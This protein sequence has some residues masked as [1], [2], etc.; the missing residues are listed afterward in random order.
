MTT[1]QPERVG[2]SFRDPL[3]QVF[4]AGDEVL[5]GLRA[6]GVA[7]F[8][9]VE[10]APF[11]TEALESR[12]IVATE[13]VDPVAAGLE[14]WPVVLRHEKVPVVSY[15]Y[16]WTFSMLRDA[17]LLQLGLTRAALADS[18]ITKDATPF[19]VQFEGARP[20]FIDVGSFEPY[21][22]GEPW[23]GYEQFCR[24]FL[25]PL[26]L[27][28]RCG[29]PFQPVLRG[30]L[31]GISPGEIRS[32][33][34]FRDRWRRGMFSHVTL[35]ARAQAKYA[36]GGD[37]LRG[38]LKTAGFGAPLIDAQLK[39]L[40]RVVRSI[41]WGSSS[42]TWSDYSD[43]SHYESEELRTKEDFVRQTCQ[44]T[45]PQR[46]V[47][48]GA[49]DGHFSKI[50]AET[51][52]TVIAVDGDHLVVD[53]LYQRLREDGDESILPLVM[54]LSD[55]SPATGW[56]GKERDAF[57]PRADADLVL[58]LALVHHL[59]ISATVPIPDIVAWLADFEADVV[60][61]FPH[62]D[63]PMV[64][65]LLSTKR[66]GLFDGYDLASFEHALADRFTITARVDLPTRT[67]FSLRRA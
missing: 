54:D 7:D 13:R 9:A 52:R 56:R 24:L 31:S 4:V 18:C 58:A 6:A 53:R 47:D 37:Q 27:Q 36:S 3:S 39:G 64:E 17:A 65:R 16:E 12:Q 55:P 28:A 19:N 14:G 11:F 15:P 2:G 20:R 38:E 29:L 48:L 41:E 1:A 5:R 8:E 21:R 26:L 49:N 42:S 22:P 45:R 40:E 44:A 30:R 67:L 25:N 62:R 57:P 61:E 50:A 60:V 46:V 32:L 43:R 66:D 33:L 59:A 10:S 51:A 35:H 63:D 34:S 23:F